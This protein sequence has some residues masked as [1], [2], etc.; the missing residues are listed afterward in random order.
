MVPFINS[1]QAQTP[2]LSAEEKLIKDFT[3][4][5]RIGENDHESNGNQLDHF[6]VRL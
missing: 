2:G 1:A 3:I 4:P 5:P 6:R